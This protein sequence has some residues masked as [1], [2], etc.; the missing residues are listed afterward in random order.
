[1]FYELIRPAD[2]HDRRGDALV[3]IQLQ[4]GA[5]IAAHERVVFQRDSHV[6]GAAEEFVH[7]GV[8]RLGEPWIDDRKV[9][10]FARELLGRFARELLQITES[11]DGY[12]APA[13][14]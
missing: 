4:H 14:V 11:E 6:G 1:M 8:E 5:A 13:I 2:A 3:A 9:P 7:S 12:L 10:A